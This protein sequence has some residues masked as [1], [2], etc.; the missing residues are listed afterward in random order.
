M[1]NKQEEKFLQLRLK[2]FSYYYRGI[3]WWADE[4]DNPYGIALLV[5]P[6]KIERRI[7]N[8]VWVSKKDMPYVVY[9]YTFKELERQVG[10]PRLIAR[11]RKQH[12]EDIIGWPIFENKKKTSWILPERFETQ[13]LM[14]I[15]KEFENKSKIRQRMAIK[16]QKILEEKEER[17][18]LLV[19]E[20]N[21]KTKRNFRFYRC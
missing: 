18:R 13:N 14:P 19:A 10:K 1:I 5:C 15:I 2:R 9:L 17:R 16:G 8:A 4:V 7:G 20:I 11:K 21:Q 6:Q 3:W 12:I